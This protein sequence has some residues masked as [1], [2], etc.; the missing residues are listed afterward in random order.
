MKTT[1]HDFIRV[2]RQKYTAIFQDG[3]ELTATEMEFKNRLDFYNWIC[4][5]RKGLGHG[6][7]EAIEER[8]TGE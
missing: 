7:L 6:R 2:P 4:R 8:L 5:N 1:I 3:T